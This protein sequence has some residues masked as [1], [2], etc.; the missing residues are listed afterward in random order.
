MRSDLEL[1]GVDIDPNVLSIAKRESEG[2]SIQLCNSPI[3][4]L[5]F[6]NRSIDVALTSFVYPHLSHEAKRQALDEV[7]RVLK[8]NGSF[9]LCDFAEPDR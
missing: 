2:R 6:G 3:T 1:T 7:R 8:R 5:P 9:L 4:A